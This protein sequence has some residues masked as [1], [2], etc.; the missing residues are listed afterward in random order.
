LFSPLEVFAGDFT[1]FGPQNYTRGSGSPE[2][3]VYNFSV[4]NPNTEYTLKIY[5][6]GLED[7]Q[8]ELVS[9]SEFFLNGVEIVSPSEFN[10][11]V[12]YL[13]KQ[14]S[15]NTANQLSVELR[16]KPGGGLTVEIVGLDNDPPTIMAALDI[17]PNAAGWHNQ[18]VTVSFTCDDAIS[19]VATC[20]DPTLVDVEGVAQVITGTA[21]DHAGN[22]QTASVVINLDKTAPTISS[23]SSSLPNANG[24][25]N[26]DPTISFSAT[27]ALSGLV[28]VSPDVTITTEGEN[29]VITGTAT[30][31]AGNTATT[32]V[33]V[34]LDKTAPAI[35]AS[36]SPLPNANGWNNTDVNVSFTGT[37]SLSGIDTLTPLTTITA[38][39]ANQLVSGT[40]VDMAGNTATASITLNID[41][42]APTLSL[43]SPSDGLQTNQAVLSVTGTATDANAIAAVDVNGSL[44]SIVGDDFEGDVTLS[45]GANTV[46]AQATDSVGNSTQAQISVTLDSIAPVVTISSPSNL[47][48]L[49]LPAVTVSGTI[50]DPSATIEVNGVGATITGG[51]YSADI[52]LGE[53]T[54]FITAV[55]QDPLGNTGTANISVMIDTTPPRVILNTPMDGATVYSSPITVT[56][57]INDIVSGTVNGNNATV[58]VNGVSATVSNRGFMA[59]NVSLNPGANTI[60]AVGTDTAGNQAQKSITVN[61]D[62]SPQAKINTLSGNN[63][64]GTIGAPLSQALVVE[65]RDAQGNLMVNHPVTFNVVRNNGYFD[66][67]PRK[68]TLNSDS[69]G[70][71]QVTWTLGTYAGAGEN[72]AEVSAMGVSA[73]ALF[74]ATGT[75]GNAALIH[76]VNFSVFRGEA[77]NALPEPMQVI[78]SDDRGNPVQGVSV[79]FTVVNGNGL[80]NNQT[81]IDVLS[82]S[83]GKAHVTWVLG[84]EEGITNNRVEATFPNNPGLPVTFVASGVIA[85]DSADTTFSGIVLSNTEEPI[86]G[87]TVSILNTPL[88][89]Q[90]DDQGQFQLTGV[91]VGAI[92]LIVDGTTA[93][94]PGTWPT[95]EFEVNTISGRDN[96]VG[97]PIYLLP[98]DVQNSQTVSPSQGENI[99]VSNVSGFSLSIAPGSVTFR[100]GSQTGSVSVTQVHRDKVPMPPPNGLNPKIVFTIQPP[101]AV[102]D[103]PAP[104]SYPNVDNRLPGE[105]IDLYSFDHDLGQWVGIGTGTVSQD[106]AYI[107]SDPGVGIIEGGWHFPAPRADTDQTNVVG[108]IEC[109]LTKNLTKDNVND[110]VEKAIAYIGKMKLKGNDKLAI[111]QM[112]DAVDSL[113]ITYET[114]DETQFCGNSEPFTITQG[115][116]EPNYQNGPTITLRYGDDRNNAQ[117]MITFLHELFHAWNKKSLQGDLNKDGTSVENGGTGDIGDEIADNIEELLDIDKEH[118]TKNTED[119][120]TDNMGQTFKG[121]A[122]K[123]ASK[124]APKCK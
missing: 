63:Q 56:G 84:P 78:V 29:Q 97:M 124:F 51:T 2:T 85:G 119:D 105:I 121:E 4:L 120:H 23:S 91:P 101:G 17:Q 102:F 71:A 122:H 47:S 79:T 80:V 75:A 77:G 65:L 53:G 93:T 8:F 67:G 19:G 40:A 117:V 68:V 6:G 108:D 107:V 22:S 49:N 20:P 34:N 33:T 112:L 61:L 92:H 58:T 70:R 116:Y 3:V 48:T 52:I 89:T 44:A 96:T 57:M 36:A 109:D 9:S 12:N 111:D 94:I 83:D 98:I 60:T 87:V 28:S 39:G 13:E 7:D 99:Q 31:L 114:T 110:W 86:P 45:E 5:N 123:F 62:T 21:I 103:P 1:V 41:K 88:E 54:R 24:W 43:T 15:V 25:N 66:G 11:N 72:R 100:D 90:T 59:E 27:D 64:T 69:L 18:D 81:Q 106:G 10:Q 73:K 55:A 26:A 37:D 30:D 95:L 104:I 74:T 118:K 113:N 82:N 50:D 16:G 35:S 46:T 42:T 38:E 32:N 115:C 14:V 76:P